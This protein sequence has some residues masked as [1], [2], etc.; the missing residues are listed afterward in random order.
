MTRQH[1]SALL[2]ATARAMTEV[3]TRHCPP[4]TFRPPEPVKSSTRCVKYGGL[5]AYS[6]SIDG[7]T[8]GRC[9]SVGCISWRDL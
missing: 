3:K 5:F 9:A 1:V 8:N 4:P 2:G 7:R 6:V